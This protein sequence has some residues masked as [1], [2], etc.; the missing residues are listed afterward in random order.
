MDTSLIP[1]EFGEPPEVSD[2]ALPVDDRHVVLPSPVAIG[3]R[4]A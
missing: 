3:R 2:H 1:P 4:L